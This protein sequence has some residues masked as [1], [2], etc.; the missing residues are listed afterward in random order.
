MVDDVDVLGAHGEDGVLEQLDGA[1]A[2]SQHG[3]GLDGLAQVAQQGAQPEGLL[4][5]GGC[6]HVL[7]LG[8]G[9]RHGLLQAAGPADGTA[10]EDEDVGGG[11]APG[12]DVAGVV[13]VAVGLQPGAASAK[14]DAVVG[15]ARQVAQHALG[16]LPVGEA[17]LGHVAGESS[18]GL[19]DVGACAD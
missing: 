9:G 7:G 10:V 17:G 6:R 12:V 15:G 4:D 3:D 19:G 11:G 2:I 13:C 5:G 14:G 16:C 18:H 1:L 8:G